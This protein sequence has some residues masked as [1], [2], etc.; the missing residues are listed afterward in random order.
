MKLLLLFT[1]YIQNLLMSITFLTMEVIKEIK[2]FFFLILLIILISLMQKDNTTVK[3][4]LLMFELE[5]HP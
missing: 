5:E 1:L 4:Q 3:E 2:P